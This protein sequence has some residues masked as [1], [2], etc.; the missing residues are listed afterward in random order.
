MGRGRELNPINEKE[1]EEK[2]KRKKVPK[3]MT[4]R[5]IKYYGVWRFGW[6][7]MVRYGTIRYNTV[8]YCGIT[9]YYW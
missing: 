2:K 6:G 1:K 8:R 7:I 5:E 9:S 4:R 3:V